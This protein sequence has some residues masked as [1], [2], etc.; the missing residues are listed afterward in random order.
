[1]FQMHW[2]IARA[3]NVIN[4]E[5]IQGCISWSVGCVQSVNNKTQW[6]A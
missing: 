5:A 2:S 1:M 6:I 4:E 3:W